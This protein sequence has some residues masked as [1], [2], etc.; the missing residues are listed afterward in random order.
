[1]S[2]PQKTVGHLER[3]AGA[4]QTCGRLFF[5]L[6]QVIQ[7]VPGCG[8]LRSGATHGVDCIYDCL[9]HFLQLLFDVIN[10][11]F[12]L[13]IVLT[14]FPNPFE[15]ALDVLLQAIK[16][17][18][19]AHEGIPCVLALF[20]LRNRILQLLLHVQ[21]LGLQL[22]G[23]APRMFTGSLV[24]KSLSDVREGL[25]KLVAIGGHHAHGV[26]RKHFIT[27]LPELAALHFDLPSEKVP[28]L[29]LE[30]SRTLPVGTCPHLELAADGTI[31]TSA[32]TLSCLLQAAVTAFSFKAGRNEVLDLFLCD[33]SF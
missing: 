14:R 28:G 6:L 4:G 25:A 18:P 31:S 13:G 16:L 29:H 26:A 27:D 7:G 8:H 11:F 5:L 23:A 12:V 20:P 2:I 24:G 9:F 30:R 10:G 3:V 32:L 1:M 21:Q 19:E 15:L 17:Y 22:H 33:D